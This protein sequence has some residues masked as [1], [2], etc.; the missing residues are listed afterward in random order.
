[1]V[2]NKKGHA[3]NVITRLSKYRNKGMLWEKHSAGGFKSSF[4]RLEKSI[5]L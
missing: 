4:F 2:L 3:Q 5:R 1:M